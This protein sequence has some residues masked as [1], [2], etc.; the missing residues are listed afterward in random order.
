MLLF[1]ADS[2]VSARI[3]MKLFGSARKRNGYGEGTGKVHYICARR[4]REAM[5]NQCCL[6]SLFIGNP[7][8]SLPCI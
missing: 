5:Y 3:G 6:L 7:S 2:L 4:Q 1:Q 8:F